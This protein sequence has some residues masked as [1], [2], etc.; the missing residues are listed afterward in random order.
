MAAVQFEDGSR[1]LKLID[2]TDSV[3]NENL[4]EE[5]KFLQLI[6]ATVSHEMRNPLNSINAQLKNQKD[7][8]QELNSILPA[9]K[10]SEEER[11]IVQELWQ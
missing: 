7:Q 6:N 5:K 1:A 8:I 11:N 4:I 2:K 3:F 10:L 9:S